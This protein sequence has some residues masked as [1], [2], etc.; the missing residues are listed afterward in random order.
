[1]KLKTLLN[2]AAAK[3]DP[4]TEVNLKKRYNMSTD[5]QAAIKSKTQRTTRND[6]IGLTKAKD[7]DQ[8]AAQIDAGFK[9]ILMAANG[10]SLESFIVAQLNQVK[11]RL[12]NRIE[13]EKIKQEKLAN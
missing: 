10:T 8:I 9:S 6:W 2:E 13:Q 3:A 11:T 7:L 5:T 4:K 1:M 12:S